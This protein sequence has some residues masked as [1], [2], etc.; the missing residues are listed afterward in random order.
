[1]YTWFP[2]SSYDMPLTLF[3]E[4]IVREH[5]KAWL[6]YISNSSA[7]KDYFEILRTYGH[8]KDMF[9]KTSFNNYMIYSARHNYSE[10]FTKYGR[11]WQIPVPFK[12]QKMPER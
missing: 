11:C 2:T 5:E 4:Q 8:G 1:M 7:E 3:G 9:I 10:V 12:K 6:D